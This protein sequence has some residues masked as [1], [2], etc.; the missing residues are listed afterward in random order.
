MYLLAGAVSTSGQE[1]QPTERGDLEK[2]L[3]PGYLGGYPRPHELV[4]V[5]SSQANILT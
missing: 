5:A 3:G 1:E 2:M 4:G